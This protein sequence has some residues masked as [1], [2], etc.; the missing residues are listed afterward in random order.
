MATAVAMAPSTILAVEK[1]EMV[2]Q[3]HA[4]PAFADRF[5][6]HMLTT[7]I[8]IEE[9]LID[10]LFNSSEKRVAPRLTSARSRGGRCGVG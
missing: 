5:L 6:T 7:N 4:Q 10:Q 3:L 8:R 1:P 9:D 2:R